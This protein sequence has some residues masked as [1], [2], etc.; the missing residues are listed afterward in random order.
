MSKKLLWIIFI[1]VIFGL[2]VLSSAGIVAGQK[3]FNSPYYYVFHQLEFG[4]I[5]GLVLMFF[6]SKINYKFFRKISFLFL[7]CVLALMILVFI[8]SFGQG[9][10]GA[11]R[12]L[13]I[14]PISF[15]PS[16]I[17]KLAI[18]LYLAAWFGGRKERIKNWAYGMAPFFIIMAFVMLLLVLQPDVGTL[19]VVM[20]IAG[21][22]YFFAGISLK[23]FLGIALM[24]AAILAFLIAVEPYRFDR[25][26]SFMNPS[27]DPRGISY[28]INQSFVSIGSGGLFGLGY[29][30]SKQK[31]G[32]LP[33]VVGDSIFAVIAEELGFVGAAA[34]VVLF[35]VLCFFLT[36]IAKNA[37]DKFSS[38]L[39]MG[40]N[41]WIMS[42]AF[43]NIAAISGL[44][45]LTGIP[46][47]FISYGGTA[48]ISLLGGLGIVLN[49]AKR[50]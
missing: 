5:P 2:A 13:N 32:F 38:L 18:V 33:E 39:V 1:L 22:I 26:K 46:L 24:L 31:F 49:V 42:Q 27:V 6:F 8:P 20:C 44:A 37:P 34:T 14:G 47:P 23:Q 12:W 35:I 25:I 21:G 36:Q 7:F 50:S 28:Q 30:H 29:G 9:L 10:K 16:E 41:L 43:I 15:Q 45:P 3:K 4:I 19:I 11:T 48:I 40:V 17:L